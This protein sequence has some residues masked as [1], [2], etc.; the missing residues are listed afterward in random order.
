M[1]TIVRVVCEAWKIFSVKCHVIYMYVKTKTQTNQTNKQNIK[2]YAVL[3]FTEY[4]NIC[5][6]LMQGKKVA[7]GFF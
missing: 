5:S 6:D 3:A 2:M 4:F 1:H 7:E